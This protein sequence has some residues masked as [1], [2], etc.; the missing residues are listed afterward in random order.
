MGHPSLEILKKAPENLK[1]FPKDLK[2]E[3]K[4]PVCPGCAQGKMHAKSYPQSNKRVSQI[5]EMVH[6]DLMEMPIES[7]HKY[8][9]VMV[10][11]DD[12]SS[13]AWIFL[14]RKKL[15]ASPAFKQWLATISKPD[16]HLNI[17]RSN[18]GGELTSKEFESFLKSKGIIHQK[19]APHEHQQ[20][21]Q[22]EHVNHTLMDKAEAMRHNASLPR[23]WW[24]FSIETVVHIYNRTPLQRT[25]GKCPLEN[26]Q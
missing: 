12:F 7:Y 17:L 14:L 6:V 21:G 25:K 13:H 20:N 3:S 24:E 10:L 2:F 8:K 16:R 19:S 15:D 9:F 18:R 11:L 5:Y 1:G 4:E 22:A 23:L 26:L